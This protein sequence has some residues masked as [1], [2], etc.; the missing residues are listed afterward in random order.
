RGEVTAPQPPKDPQPT[1]PGNLRDAR[2]VTNQLKQI[3]LAYHSYS[4][5]NGGKA[6]TKA[7]DLGPYVENDARILKALKDDFVFFYNVRITQMTQGTSNTILA[8][9][10]GAEKEG[11]IVLFGDG[12]VKRLSADEFAKAA[13]AGKCQHCA[14]TE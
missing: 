9:E 2:T 14:S 8:H 13:K 4:D 10:K 11:G 1:R 12:S 3:G 7:E 5:A 6:P